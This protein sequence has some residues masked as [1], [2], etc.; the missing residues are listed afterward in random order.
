MFCCRFASL[1]LLP[2]LE[3]STGTPLK[4]AAKF[5][6]TYMAEKVPTMLKRN[7]T[8]PVATGRLHLSWG[9]ERREER[10]TKRGGNRRVEGC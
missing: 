4:R 2:Y 1:Q 6:P 3:N 8:I 10:G 9:R 7:T 5:R